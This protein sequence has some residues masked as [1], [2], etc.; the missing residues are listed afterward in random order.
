MKCENLVRY[1]SDD[2]TEKLVTLRV[3]ERKFEIHPVTLGP[4]H[5]SELVDALAA[6]LGKLTAPPPEQA[7]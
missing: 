3:A 7:G 5:A 2:G 4:E 6:A 1:V